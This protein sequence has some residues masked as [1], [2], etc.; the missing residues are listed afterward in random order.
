[1]LAAAVAA[2]VAAAAAV[3]P[4]AVLLAVV[5]AGLC[6]VVRFPPLGLVAVIAL[7]SCEELTEGSPF[8]ERSSILVTAGS[9]LY[10][11]S[12]GP[13]P[14]V[15]VAIAGV[16]AVS[17]VATRARPGPRI[18]WTPLGAL[19]AALV[20]W[21]AATGVAEAVR[22]GSPA[23]APVSAAAAA[24]PW[25]ALAA[26]FA[27]G[28]LA[29]A[30]DRL[31]LLGVLAAGLVVVKGVIA[32]LVAGRGSAGRLDAQS[33][34]VFLDT[35]TPLMAFGVLCAAGMTHRWPSRAVQ[36][37]VA[38][39]AAAVVLASFR[40]SIW[41][42]AAAVLAIALVV[43]GRT[44]L[45]VRTALVVGAVVVAL[46]LAP[47][48][49]RSQLT[50][51]VVG[52]VEVVT[53]GPGEGSAR[54]HVTDIAAGSTIVARSP[55][56][57]LGPASRQQPE[58][59]NTN[60]TYLYVH[61]ELLQV[62]VRYGVLGALLLV[63]VLA[64]LSGRAVGA[65]SRSDHPVVV[66]AAGM[67]VALAAPLMTAPFLSTTARWPALVGLAAGVIDAARRDRRPLAGDTATGGR[68]RPDRPDQPDEHAEM[69]A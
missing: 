54:A 36:L 20:A 21:S 8:A 42:M 59:V 41:L 34:I 14:V 66:G 39:A 57:G 40:R 52:A 11:I 48:T 67:C 35:A 50:D 25:L 19:L 64:A 23:S 13:V 26:G 46:A 12:A 60:A 29:V 30:A 28:R 22:S 2:A 58:L 65:L 24:A 63:V 53:G 33:G 62:W 9:N 17:W 51:R 32:A 31:A 68:H 45:L 16:A 6:L 27:L 37:V 44:Y 38:A 56:M 18:G 15:P 7:A 49:V 5:A 1:V 47:P 10:W 69:T 3:R 61:N 4:P 55:L 43:R